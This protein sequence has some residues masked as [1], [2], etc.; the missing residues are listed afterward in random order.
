[1]TSEGKSRWWSSEKW[2]AQ[3][4]LLDFM[5]NWVWTCAVKHSCIDVGHSRLDVFVVDKRGCAATFHR[6]LVSLEGFVD[7]LRPLINGTGQENDLFY[8]LFRERKPS[9]LFVG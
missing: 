2:K 9:P 4:L 1:M 8:F 6:L 3:P 7:R 5:T